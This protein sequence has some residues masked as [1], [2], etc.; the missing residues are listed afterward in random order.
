MTTKCNGTHK[1]QYQHCMEVSDWLSFTS[2][3]WK[4]RCLWFLHNMKLQQRTHNLKPQ[5]PVKDVQTI[6][7]NIPSLAQISPIFSSTS[8]QYFNS[9]SLICPIKNQTGARLEKLSWQRT[10]F[11]ASAITRVSFTCITFGYR[12]TN[13]PISLNTHGIQDRCIR[14]FSLSASMICRNI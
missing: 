11:P 14:L 6:P 7:K 4:I 9:A 5:S 12:L 2:S 10:G 8:A 1:W 3:Y 13:L